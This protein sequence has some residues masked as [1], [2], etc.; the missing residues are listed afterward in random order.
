TRPLL[1]V[2]TRRTAEHGDLVLG[3]LDRL[4][5][6]ALVE[7][8]LG[9]AP[10]RRVAAE[11]AARSGGNPLFAEHLVRLA[12]A[13]GLS[14][15]VAEWNLPLTVESA[16][17]ARL[18]ELPEELREAAHALAVLGSDVELAHARLALGSRADDWIARL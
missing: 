14:G 15:E 4:A 6:A 3:P 18:D 9:S 5:V 7:R 12:R 10:A 8:E 2:T 11:V 1:V 17:Q 16:V 13:H